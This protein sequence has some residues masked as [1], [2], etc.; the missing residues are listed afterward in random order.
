MATVVSQH[1]RHIGRHLE[2]FKNF[3][4]RK[5]SGNF[6]EI[7]RKHVFAASNRKI[8]KNRVYEKEIRTNFLKNLQFS[9]SNFNLHN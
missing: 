4:L 2:F 6:T 8:I 1:A 3:I 9:I 5:T 7:S